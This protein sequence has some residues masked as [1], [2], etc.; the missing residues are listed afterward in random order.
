MHELA[1][2]FVVVQNL[3]ILSILHH[4]VDLVIGLIVD[5]F[6]ESNQVP[7]AQ[8]FVNVELSH[9][10]DVVL[11]AVLSHVA[12]F[13]GLHHELVK[14]C[15]DLAEGNLRVGCRGGKRIKQRVLIIR[16]VVLVII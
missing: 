16:K 13:E 11:V 7:V 10:L 15:V 4:E 14:A 12:A 6:D 3:P 2:C 1:C 8:H 5:H 9:R